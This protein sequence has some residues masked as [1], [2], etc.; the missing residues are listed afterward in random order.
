MAGSLHERLGEALLIRRRSAAPVGEL[1]RGRF[2][3][4]LLVLAASAL[5]AAFIVVANW[6]LSPSTSLLTVVRSWTG[7]DFDILDLNG[8]RLCFGQ[9]IRP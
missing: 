7:R 1:G 4:I 9:I 3:V 8:Y 2:A 5:L 6:P